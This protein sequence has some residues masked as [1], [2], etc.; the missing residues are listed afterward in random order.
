MQNMAGQRLAI[1]RTTS[2]ASTAFYNGPS[3]SS[4]SRSLSFSC[5]SMG[6]PAVSMVV[7][8][9]INQMT[10]YVFISWLPCFLPLTQKHGDIRMERKEKLL[11]LRL[12]SYS[13]IFSDNE[14]YPRG[15]PL[16]LSTCS[17]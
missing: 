6:S 2:K 10:Q 15:P 7:L 16:S 14:P 4:I 11:I 13:L 12:F 5:I 17:P 8:M 9:G 3:A 1:H